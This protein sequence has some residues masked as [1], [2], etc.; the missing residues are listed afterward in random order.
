MNSIDRCLEVVLS[1]NFDEQL[2]CDMKSSEFATKFLTKKV[3]KV[4]QHMKK[5]FCQ[6]LCNNSR[7]V[8]RPSRALV[9]REY[10]DNKVVEIGSE[11]G[12][13]FYKIIHLENN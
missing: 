2:S 1:A 6:K 13:K 4:F 10:G 3:Q 12:S 7:V 5:T 8:R 11:R 9:F